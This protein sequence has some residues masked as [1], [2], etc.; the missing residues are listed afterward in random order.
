MTLSV[1]ADDTS[2]S[3]TNRTFTISNTV[4][5]LIINYNYVKNNFSYDYVTLTLFEEGENEIGTYNP[6]GQ[7]F[8]L[9]V[10]KLKSETDYTLIIKAGKSGATYTTTLLMSVN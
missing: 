6:S 10:S 7:T 5:S 1:L 9:P 3:F 2:I 4:S 8:T